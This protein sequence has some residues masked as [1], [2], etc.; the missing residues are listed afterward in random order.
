MHHKSISQFLSIIINI[1]SKP[2]HDCQ[3]NL[4]RSNFNVTMI[5]IGFVECWEK[6][7]VSWM[8]DIYILFI[9]QNAPL[10]S[11]PQ[12][13]SIFVAFFACC[14]R[15]FGIQLLNGDASKPRI[16]DFKFSLLILFLTL[17]LFFL[18]LQPLPKA[19]QKWHDIINLFFLQ[20]PL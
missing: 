16:K 15:S 5:H 19:L 10:S 3:P 20:L 2:K 8:S 14:F 6:A 18:L 17:F 1:F 13:D 7:I 4:I 9:S 11:P 12:S